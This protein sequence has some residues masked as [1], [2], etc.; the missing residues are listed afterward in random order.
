MNELKKQTNITM[1]T[2]VNA[3][4]ASVAEFLIPS[5]SL[6]VS[7]AMLIPGTATDVTDLDSTHS[8]QCKKRNN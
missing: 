1:I 4:A 6:E 5:K 2:I 3:N 7:D 8:I